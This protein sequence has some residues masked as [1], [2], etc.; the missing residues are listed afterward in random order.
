MPTTNYGWVPPEV[1]GDQDQWGDELNALI[2]EVDADLFTVSEVADAAL[3]K[4][5]GEMTGALKLKTTAAA[6]LSLGN[7]SGATELDLTDAQSFS[8]TI[9]GATTFSFAG[10][11]AGD[12]SS[13]FILKLT[14]AGAFTITW[15]V[16]IRWPGG[17]APDFTAAGVDTLVFLTF[18][19]GTTWQAFASGLDVK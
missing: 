16:S 11:I 3:P 1:G 18:D 5:G 4:A 15:P 14:N 10:A 17:S 19:N 2:D 8:A 6:H 12:Y 7:I 9:A 13:G